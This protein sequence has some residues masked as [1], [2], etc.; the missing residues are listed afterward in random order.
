MSDQH[1]YLCIHGVDTPGGIETST[2][3]ECL[4]VGLVLRPVEHYQ[5]EEPIR[6][7]QSQLRTRRQVARFLDDAIRPTAIEWVTATTPRVRWP[8]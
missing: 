7:S 1:T 3:S 4:R 5:V 2:C 6:F 8:L